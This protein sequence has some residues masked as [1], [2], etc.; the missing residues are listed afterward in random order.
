[1]TVS[2]VVAALQLSFSM[3]SATF[4]RLSEQASTKN[5]PSEASAGIVTETVPDELRPG[6][7]EGT[8][9]VPDNSSAY[10]SLVALN[11]R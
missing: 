7:K 9:R 11:D 3:L 10:E 4:L 6:D 8:A 2:C 1:M 5:V